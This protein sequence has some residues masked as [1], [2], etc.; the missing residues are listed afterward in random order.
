MIVKI[1]PA[2]MKII[3]G[4]SITTHPKTWILDCCNMTKT[5]NKIAAKISD[6]TVVSRLSQ[7]MDW[8]PQN[9]TS[10]LS[11][12]TLENVS[13]VRCYS[14]LTWAG[15]VRRSPSIYITSTPGGFTPQG[16]FT[17]FRFWIWESPFPKMGEWLLIQNIHDITTVWKSLFRQW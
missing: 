5:R 7:C 1:N 6:F 15:V 16:L 10:G 12:V 9:N 3:K 17:S 14:H 4:F 11:Y 2:N 13:G 8:P